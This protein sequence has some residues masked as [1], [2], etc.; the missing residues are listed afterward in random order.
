[1]ENINLGDLV[2]DCE[3]EVG[4]RKP[5]SYFHSFSGNFE[6]YKEIIEK[7]LKE[8]EIDNFIKICDNRIDLAKV[9]L[10]D[11]ATVV[12]FFITSLSI[13]LVLSVL[14]QDKAHLDR[15]LDLLAGKFGYLFPILIF[16]LLAGIVILFG[17]LINYRTQIYIWTAFKEGAILNKKY[18]SQKIN[19]LCPIIYRKY[20]KYS[21]TARRRNRNDCY[22][23]ISWFNQIKAL[24]QS[25]KP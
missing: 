19:L 1:M 17:L 18:T 13:V 10:Q 11:I 9:F 16:A 20:L 23:G 2:K 8:E 3:K 21:R 5:F 15:F 24:K 4:W 22:T 6:H 14:E 12:G 7:K 25:Q